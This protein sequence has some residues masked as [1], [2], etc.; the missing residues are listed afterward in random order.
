MNTT[1]CD[2]EDCIEGWLWKEHI[3]EFP[4]PCPNHQTEDTPDNSGQPPPPPN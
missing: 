1:P 2:D 4:Q 3:S